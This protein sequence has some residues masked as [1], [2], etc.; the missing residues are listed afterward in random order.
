MT[1]EFKAG[2]LPN[3]PTKPR[4][5]FSRFS[6]GVQVQFPA[7]KDWFSRVT[8][9][10]MYGN[11]QYGDCVWA[12]IGHEIEQTT[13]YGQGV[14]KEVTLADVLKG[15]HD[16]TGFD[17]VT[18]ANDNGT[19]IQD[20]LNYWRK[21]G[22]GG[23]KILA[24]AEVDVKNPDELHAALDLFGFLSLGIDFPA[25]AMDQFNAGQP[26]DVVSGSQIEGGHAINAGFYDIAA[27]EWKIVTWGKVQTM[28]Q[29]FW[30]KYVTE[31]WVVV[32]PEWVAA[33]KNPDGVDLNALGSD[34]VQI[35]GGANPFPNVAPT[36]TPAP[37]PT[38]TPVPVPTPTPSPT[39]TPTPVPTPP[40]DDF[41]AY[42]RQ[43]SSEHHVFYKTFQAKLRA[44]LATQP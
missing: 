11:D 10:P 27:K 13:Q 40:V 8:D 14:T 30:D 25:S 42:A 6:T 34:F 22:V 19:V 39:P 35:T 38:P 24:F 4:L 44:W 18:G 7:T 26:W 20:A 5:K 31:A 32:S 12:K 15:Y 41:V 23:H 36:P 16:V 21:T 33:N 17:P 1:I 29:A 2:R 37:V 9:W 3:D 28:T 43:W